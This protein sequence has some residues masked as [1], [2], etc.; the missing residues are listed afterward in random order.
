M[1][2]LSKMGLLVVMLFTL[3]ACNIERIVDTPIGK[4]EVTYAA[5]ELRL[6]D[7]T[8]IQ[9]TTMGEIRDGL[10]EALQTQIKD[11]PNITI[12][13]LVSIVLS[14]EDANSPVVPEGSARMEFFEDETLVCW[15]LEKELWEQT[16]HWEESGRG[17]WSYAQG[18]MTLYIDQVVYKCAVEKLTNK[19][20]YMKMEYPD[21]SS[22]TNNWEDPA[23]RAEEGFDLGAYSELISIL[24]G[25]QISVDL[26]LAHL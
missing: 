13:T 16:S 1:K 26:Q 19:R 21:L 18:N 12:K 25:M 8:V 9:G 10:V 5:L 6:A 2:Y 17:E 11:L 14:E 22:L 20:L 4:W 15:R 24:M 3:V 23:T 7:G